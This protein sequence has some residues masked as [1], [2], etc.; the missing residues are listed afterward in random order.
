MLDKCILPTGIQYVSVYYCIQLL[1]NKIFSKYL[2]VLFRS[3][4][5]LR[6]EYSLNCSCK[7]RL[8][9]NNFRYH[10]DVQACLFQ[11]S[12]IIIIVDAIQSLCYRSSYKSHNPPKLP[13]RL[14]EKIPITTIYTCV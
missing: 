5:M 2:I 9:R 13:I 1:T 7:V 14:L 10:T 4:S 8:Y 12:R 11:F 6:Q 3:I